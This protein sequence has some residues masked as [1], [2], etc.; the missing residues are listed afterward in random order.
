MGFS[1]SIGRSYPVD[2]AVLIHFVYIYVYFHWNLIQRLHGVPG[3]SQLRSTNEHLLYGI[4]QFDGSYRNIYHQFA[5][6]NG[7]CVRLLDAIILNQ[8]VLEL[9]LYF[10]FVSFRAKIQQSSFTESSVAHGIQSC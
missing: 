2:G 5:Y 9:E 8:A 1:L 10:L 3:G 4:L 6:G 7:E